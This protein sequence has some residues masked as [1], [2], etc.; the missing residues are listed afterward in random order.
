MANNPY[1]S[2]RPPGGGGFRSASSAGRECGAA[3][4][5]R[6]ASGSNSHLWS[7]GT[8]CVLACPICTSVRGR[9][10]PRPG[11]DCS[12]RGEGRFGSCG[13]ASVV[14]ENRGTGVSGL[15]GRTGCI[16][17]AKCVHQSLR[18]EP[19]EGNS[20]LGSIAQFCKGIRNLPMRFSSTC[21]NASGLESDSDGWYA[22]ISYRSTFRIC[23]PGPY[24][25][26]RENHD[27]SLPQCM[28]IRLQIDS[29]HPECACL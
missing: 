10:G 28:A 27:R 15:A 3:R 8:E 21:S 1:A 16:L 18:L 2:H 17:G 26:Q 6:S 20:C 11:C 7:S 14:D 5:F 23:R 29:R 4:S 9:E 25:T 22:V 13:P 12:S 24:D 19:S